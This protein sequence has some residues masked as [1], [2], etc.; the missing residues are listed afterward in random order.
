M[1]ERETGRAAAGATTR[2]VDAL[3]SGRDA[4]DRD[5]ELPRLVDEVLGDAGAGERDDALRQEV[6]QF[7]VAAER[8]GASV[9]VPVRLADDLVDVGFALR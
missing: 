5:A 4:L 1:C 7:V 3:R 8:G 6:Q 9:A 2:P